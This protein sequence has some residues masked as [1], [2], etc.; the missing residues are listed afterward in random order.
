MLYKHKF[1]VTLSVNIDMQVTFVPA[2]QNELFPLRKVCE[3]WF[4]SRWYV[5]HE[6]LSFDGPVLAPS[7][8]TRLAL[9]CRFISLMKGQDVG[10]AVSGGQSFSLALQHTVL[11]VEHPFCCNG[12]FRCGWVRAPCC[13]ECQYT[14]SA[15]HPVCSSSVRPRRL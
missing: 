3:F 1:V 12:L 4:K 13:W 10:H 7:Q 5:W 15:A 14:A 11:P 9:L 6:E 2:S 8:F